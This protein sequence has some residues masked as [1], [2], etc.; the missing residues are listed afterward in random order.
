M[1][2]RVWAQLRVP[3]SGLP[4]DENV[5]GNSRSSRAVFE[6][7]KTDLYCDNA[8]FRLV[9]ETHTHSTHSLA[10]RD[11]CMSPV[12]C[13]CTCGVQESRGIWR[14][15]SKSEFFE[16]AGKDSQYKRDSGRR[17]INFMG[18]ILDSRVGSSCHSSVPRRAAVA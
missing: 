4:R 7:F 10:P 3:A 13:C 2:G 14:T 16:Y 6:P 1:R 15:L 11:L 18:A 17:G 8:L 12:R 5:S 9:Y